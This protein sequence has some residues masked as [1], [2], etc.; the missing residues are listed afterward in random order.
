MSTGEERS[1]WVSVGS[2]GLLICKD[3]ESVQTVVNS[4]DMN[5]EQVTHC[6]RMTLGP[7][8]YALGSVVNTKLPSQPTP[9]KLRTEFRPFVSLLVEQCDM[10][11]HRARCQ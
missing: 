1:S 9:A 10:L 11:C 6:Q 4:G 8:F 7:G 3:L 5:W 2:L